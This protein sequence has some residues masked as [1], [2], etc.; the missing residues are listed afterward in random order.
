MRNNLIFNANIT[1]CGKSWK[2]LQ[3]IAFSYSFINLISYGFEAVVFLCCS[4]SYMV[5]Y[6][7]QFSYGSI[8]YWLYIGRHDVKMISAAP[9]FGIEVHSLCKIRTTIK[10]WILKI[11]WEIFNIFSYLYFD[12]VKEV[13]YHLQLRYLKIQWNIYKMVT[14]FQNSKGKSL[15]PRQILY[16]LKIFFSTCLKIQSKTSDLFQYLQES[17]TL[18]I[19]LLSHKGK[20]GYDLEKT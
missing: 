7:E 2:S 1:R 18:A 11:V 19:F 20:I 15:N 10:I 8:K 16:I 6:N 14:W 13:S 4:I 12:K 17:T 9:D 3:I 5:D